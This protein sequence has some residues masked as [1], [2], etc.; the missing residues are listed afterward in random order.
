MSEK[1]QEERG[2]RVTDRRRFSES[3]ED[4]GAPEAPAAAVGSGAMERDDEPP[5]TEEPVTFATF[6]LSLSTQALLHLGEIANPISRQL[7]RDLGA[8]KQVIDIL[9]ILREKTRNNLE[10]GEESMLEAMLYDLRMRYVQLV[11][12]S[13]KEGA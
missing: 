7:E 8:A 11:R 4:R 3:G 12:T 5:P 2:F 6:I 9:G 10:P 1:D 13:V